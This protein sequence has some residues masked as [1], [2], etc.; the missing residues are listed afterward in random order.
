VPGNCRGRVDGESGIR[1]VESIESREK[2]KTPSP[3]KA[4]DSRFQPFVDSAF[5]SFQ[6]KHA[7]KPLWQG[8]DYKALRRL[9]ASHPPESLSLSLLETLWRNYLNSSELF[10]VKQ[11]D[12]LA[13]FC[14]N[15]DKFSNGPILAE[16]KKEGANGKSSVSD[17]IHTTLTAFRLTEQKPIN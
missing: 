9:L 1:E 8:K 10:I 11:A 16:A 5:E 6:A 14:A 15:P 2:R 13:Y 17:N 3:K 7:R 4:P 12:S